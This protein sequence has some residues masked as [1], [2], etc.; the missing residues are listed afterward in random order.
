[1]TKLPPLRKRKGSSDLV[2]ATDMYRRAAD[3]GITAA[4]ISLAELVEE[5]G[6]RVQAT[7]WA[8]RLATDHGDSDGLL[9]LIRLRQRAGD[10]AGAARMQRFGLEDDDAQG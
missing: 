2:G 10:Q 3:H 5:Q 8:A 1:M 4:L 9:M 7:N 6:D